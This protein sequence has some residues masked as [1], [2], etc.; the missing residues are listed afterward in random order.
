MALGLLRSDDALE[1]FSSAKL[2]LSLLA[3]GDVEDRSDDVLRPAVGVSHQGAVNI[4]PHGGAVLAYA[5]LLQPEC[6]EFARHHSPVEVLLDGP[7]VGGS[8]VA[9]L[10]LKQFLACVSGK[11]AVLVINTEVG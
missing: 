1:Q 10:A 8:D 5:P 7:V 6:R 2:F 11:A 3:L 9:H 4:N